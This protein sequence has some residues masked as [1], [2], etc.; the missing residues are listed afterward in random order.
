LV[1]EGTTDAI[2]ALTGKLG[3]LEGL[4]V[5]SVLTNYREDPDDDHEAPDKP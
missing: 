3:R 1:V 2:G 4:Q 5:K